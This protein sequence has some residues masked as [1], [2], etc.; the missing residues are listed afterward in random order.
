LRHL[1]K[2]LPEITEYLD[3]NSYVHKIG[4][5]VVVSTNA[6][7]HQLPPTA[8]KQKEQEVVFLQT[9]FTFVVVGIQ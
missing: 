4:G 6:M 9:Q 2:N 1:L 7:Q 8:K 3:I 5:E